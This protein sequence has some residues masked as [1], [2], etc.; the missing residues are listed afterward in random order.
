MVR[1]H[2]RQLLDK[3][4]PLLD[5]F[6]G[7]VVAF[8]AGQVDGRPDGVGNGVFH[9]ELKFAK[10][11]GFDGDFDFMFAFGEVRRAGLNGD[12][13]A[14][15]KRE[16]M[17][18]VHL[19]DRH[20]AAVFQ[21]ANDLLEIHWGAVDGDACHADDF[22]VAQAVLDGELDSSG[23]ILQAAQGV[24]LLEEE[25]GNHHIF[26]PLYAIR[27]IRRNGKSTPPAARGGKCGRSDAR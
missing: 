27:K 5:D 8:I 15:R 10:R 11:A 13:G 23:G 9:F 6:G 16:R 26:Y 24:Q 7:I 2:T 25:T 19:R 12:D 20:G 22:S 17:R 1:L 14:Q 3:R 18:G 21:A 4:L